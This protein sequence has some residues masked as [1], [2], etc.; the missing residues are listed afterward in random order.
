MDDNYNTT[1]A[2]HSLIKQET[3]KKQKKITVEPPTR[4]K[5]SID[6]Q[7]IIEIEEEKN[8]YLKGEGEEDERQEK[9]VVK[10]GLGLGVGVAACCLLPERSNSDQEKQFRR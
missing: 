8:A 2:I 7:E 1:P 3:K 9:R 6:R 10:L 4:R 5:K